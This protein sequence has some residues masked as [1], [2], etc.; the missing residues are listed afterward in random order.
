MD[1]QAESKKGLADRAAGAAKWS[2]LTQVASKLIAPITTMVL[3]RI[4]TPAAFGVVASATMITSLADMISD[5]GFQTYLIQHRFGED[6]GGRLA[7]SA[8]VA[9]W[10]NLTVS[11]A[12]VLLITISRDALA[13]WVGSPGWGTLLVVASLSLPLTSLSSVQ[14][15]I[16]QRSYDFKTLFSAKVGSSLLIFIV[17]V[18]VALLGA[19]PWAM[20]AGT[21]TSNLFLSLWLTLKSTWKPQLIYSW[22]VLREMLTFGLW[23]LIEAVATWVNT[24][25]GTFVIGV[26]MDHTHVGYYKTSTSMTASIISLITTAVLPVA[27]VALSEVQDDETRFRRVFFRLQAYLSLGVVPIAAGVLVYH[28]AVTLLLLGRQWMET[29]LFFGLWT[30]ASCFVVSVGYLCSQAYYALGKPQLCTFVQV[31]YL[32]PFLPVLWVSASTNYTVLTWL[33]PLARLVL[34]VIQV[35]VLWREVRI[36]LKEILYNMRWVFLATIVSMVPG[37]IVTAVTT[38]FFFSIAAATLSVIMY[39]VFVLVHPVLSEQT[40]DL[41]E[42]VGFDGISD[43]LARVKGKMR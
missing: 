29:A 24:W 7:L 1:E 30:G 13:A 27:L 37:L 12:I 34:P 39:T 28:D 18:P 16:H 32:V 20:V 40:I 17:S 15:A 43:R 35:A 22:T 10:T 6:E 19:G 3:A 33:M 36:G 8:C 42:K 9:F 25:I 11:L 21:L 31:V 23:I 41:L 26:L 14:T 5:A 38:S 4:L 2:V